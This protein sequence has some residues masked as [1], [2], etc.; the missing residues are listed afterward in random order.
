MKKSMK[1]GALLVAGVFALSGCAGADSADVADSAPESGQ[2]ESAAGTPAPS[3]SLA[4]GQDQYTADELE[5]AL[6]AV[7]DA[8][9]TTGQI[10]NDATLRPG[11]AQVESTL[12]DLTITPEVCSDLASDNIAEK[13]D[14][15]NV[16]IMQFNAT[17]TLTV[18]S[19]DDASFID[20][21]VETNAQQMVDCT[22]FQMEVSGQVISAAAE[23]VSA[24]TDAV[25][26]QAYRVTVAAAGQEA[27]TVQVSA[28]S[29]TT[30]IT[31]SMTNPADAQ[32]ALATAE[33]LINALLA[34]LK[35]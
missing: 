21:Q 8:E 9:G 20:R 12:E 13:I 25:T 28:F 15:A 6:T 35:K 4:V 29:G 3:P 23:E 19:Y 16:A 26:T 34:E 5:A 1:A 11:L 7:R 33:D 31:A 17:D 10:I 24:S 2:L 30:N 27:T 14:S 22:E 32:G 18:F